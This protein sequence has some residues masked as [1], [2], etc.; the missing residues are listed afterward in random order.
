MFERDHADL[1][2]QDS[3]SPPGSAR[4]GLALGLLFVSILVLLPALTGIETA[5]TSDITL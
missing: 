1:A 4:T 3:V 2:L 5:T